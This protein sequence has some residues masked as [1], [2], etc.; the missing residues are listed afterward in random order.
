M[1]QKRPQLSDTETT[2]LITNLKL[3]L[4]NSAH[5]PFRDVFNKDLSNGNNGYFRQHLCNSNWTFTECRTAHKVPI[6]DTATNV[7][8][9]CRRYVTN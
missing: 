9:S 1:P 8:V 5:R 3:R 7:K 2:N 6:A 4:I